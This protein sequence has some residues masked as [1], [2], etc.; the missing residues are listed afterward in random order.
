MAGTTRQGTVRVIGTEQLTRLAAD[1][2][3]QADGSRRV[4]Q[5]SRELRRAALPL[6]RAARA[7]ARGLPS[8][9]VN[10][11]RGR[12]SLRQ[13]LARSVSVQVKTK[14]KK[15]N[16]SV[17]TSPKKMADGEKALPAYTEGTKGYH[18]WRHPVYK[19]PRKDAP[20]VSQP[21]T[22]W[23]TRAI[24]PGEHAAVLAAERVIETTARDLENGS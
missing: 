20:W 3:E 7:G 14:G 2:R 16:V 15:A 22:P 5:L 12:R 13:A 21:A 18:R 9:G 8:K 11:S 19:R 1:L 6:A 23:F 24:E 17:Y 10:A 4:A